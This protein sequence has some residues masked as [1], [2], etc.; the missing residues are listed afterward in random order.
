MHSSSV[1][2]APPHRCDVGQYTGTELVHLDSTESGFRLI[3][4]GYQRISMRDNFGFACARDGPF[5]AGHML[6]LSW[7][8]IPA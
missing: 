5:N 3:A 2:T 4:V 8:Y 7:A 6:I 1:L